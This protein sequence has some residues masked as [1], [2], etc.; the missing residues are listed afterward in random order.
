M[1][2]RS[3]RSL[4]LIDHHMPWFLRIYGREFAGVPGSQFTA[5]CSAGEWY[6]TC[7]ASPRIDAAPEPGTGSD[8]THH[9]APRR[10]PEG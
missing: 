1:E 6:T 3:Q 9:A 4:D 8:Q 2:E 7:T 10:L 5:Y